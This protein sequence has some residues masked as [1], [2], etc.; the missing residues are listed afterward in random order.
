M[1]KSLVPILVTALAA[2]AAPAHAAVKA[3]EVIE[4]A[5]DGFVRPAYAKFHEEAASADTAVAALCKDPSQAS[6]DTARTRFSDLVKAWSQ[7][8]II[9]FGPITEDNRLERILYWP[10]RKSIGLRQVQAAIAGEDETSADAKTIASKSVAMQGLGALEYIL[11]GT[12]AGDL[13]GKDGAYRCA[14][15][16]AVAGNI[17]TMSAA[18]DAAWAKPDGFAKLW[19]NPGPDNPVYRD[20]TESVTELMEV[21]INGLE[22]VRDVRVKGFLGERPDDDKA[23]GAILWRSGLT[24]ASLAGNLEGMDRLFEASKV[25]DALSDDAKWMADSTHILLQNGVADARSVNGPIDKALAD[26]DQR[27]KF[28]HFRLVTSSLSSLIGTRMTAEFGLTAGF[29]SLDGD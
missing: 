5:I 14:F 23:K 19:A 25:G 29:S 3:S 18:L 26:P 27:A 24:G 10:D 13:A 9:Q 22:M 17:A 20:G 28:E 21:F 8:E 4:R 2:W 7:A 15:G 12:G 1:N 6:L 16:A 11:Y